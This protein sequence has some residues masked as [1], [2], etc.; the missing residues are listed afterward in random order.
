LTF[1]FGIDVESLRAELEKA[2]EAA[3]EAKG[4][5]RKEVMA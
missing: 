3:D 2:L 5:R 1:P 4:S